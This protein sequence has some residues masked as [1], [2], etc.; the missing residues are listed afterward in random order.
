MY[1]LVSKATYY[2]GLIDLGWLFGTATTNDLE[3]LHK[4]LQS[5]EKQG[6]AVAHLMKNQTTLLN[7]TVNH[8][9]EHEG[10]IDNLT[11]TVNS[12]KNEQ[13]R[14]YDKLEWKQH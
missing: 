9:I 10:G 8:L 5:L 3:L 13:K 1:S 14:E 4:R 6:E 7:V 11:S 2:R 12:I